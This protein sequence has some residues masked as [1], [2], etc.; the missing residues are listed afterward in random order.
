[1]ERSKKVFLLGILVVTLIL[2]IVAGL[3]G[4]NYFVVP[5]LGRIGQFSLPI[6]LGF[7]FLAGVVTFFSPCAFALFPGY[8]AFYL[9]A[10]EGDGKGNR[11]HPAKLGMLA[12]LGIITFFILIS[13]ILMIVGK[14]IMPYLGFVAPMLGAFLIILGIILFAGYTF[15]TGLIQR[16]LDRLKTKEKRSKRN[17]YLFGVGYGAVSMGCTLPLL[18]ALVI[19]PLTAGKIFNVFLSLLVYAIAMSI[20]MIF[21]TYLVDWSENSLIKRMVSSTATIKKLSGLAL[22]I[23]GAYLVY[24]NIFYSM[25]L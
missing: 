16:L 19:V 13:A 12:S 9:G 7:S 18:F 14:Q 23:I 3:R 21:V 1:M 6:L 8:V 15:K 24:Y 5:N 22:I 10:E 20:L 25:L 17:I 11:E 2:L 4:W